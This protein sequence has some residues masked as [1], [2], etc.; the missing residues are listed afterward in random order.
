MRAGSGGEGWARRPARRPPVSGA[1]R[2]PAAGG[3]RDEVEQREE[4]R[5]GARFC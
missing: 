5:Q 4:G 2:E 3:A 1:V